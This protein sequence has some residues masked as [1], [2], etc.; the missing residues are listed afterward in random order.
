MRIKNSKCCLITIS[1]KKDVF[2]RHTFESAGL[3]ENLS[4]FSPLE[5]NR[6]IMRSAVATASLFPKFDQHIPATFAAPS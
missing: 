2:Y 3:V 1:R 4:F 6:N 5:S